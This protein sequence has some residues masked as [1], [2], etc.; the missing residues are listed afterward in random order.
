VLALEA[1]KTLLLDAEE[2]KQL[3]TKRKVTLTTAS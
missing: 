2:V 3:T 1:E